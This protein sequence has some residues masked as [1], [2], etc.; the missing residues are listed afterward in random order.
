MYLGK[1]CF[2]LI[3]NGINILI[4]LITKTNEFLDIVV[5]SSLTIIIS[6]YWKEVQIIIVINYKKYNNT[7]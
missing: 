6:Y 1:L 3:Q 5:S 7:V 2:T 4:T